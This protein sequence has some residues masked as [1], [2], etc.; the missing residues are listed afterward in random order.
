MCWRP[1]HNGRKNRIRRTLRR[2]Q[3]RSVILAKNETALLQFPS[4]RV[5]WSQREVLAKVML[6]AIHAR[7]VVFGYLKLKT[8][9]RLFRACRRQRAEDF[10]AFLWQ[11]HYHYRGRYIVML[12]NSDT[13]AI[14]PNH[15][16]SPYQASRH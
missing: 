4:L 5:M 16:T 10:Q 6:S 14:P 3:E 12:S 9:H 1:T 15:R 8:E 7:R 2:L 13:R 11:A